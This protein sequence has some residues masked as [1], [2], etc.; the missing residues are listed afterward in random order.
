[1]NIPVFAIKNMKRKLI[2]TLLLVLAVMAVTGTLFSATVFISSMQNALRIGTHRLGADIILAPKEY[3]HQARS[4]LLAGEPTTFYISRDIIDKARQVEGVEAASPQLF[5][6]PSSF[7]C[8]FNVDVF[9]VAFDP[10]T[11]FTI[12]PWIKSQKLGSLGH[13]KVIVGRNVPVIA[14]DQISFFGTLFEVAANLEPTGMRFFD[15]SVFLTMDD[16]YRMAENSPEKAMQ[17][18]ELPRDE[19]STVLIKVKEGYDPARVAIKLEYALSDI[20]AIASDEVIST[21]RGQ[22]GGL[23]KG[24]VAVSVVFW[25]FALVM[26]GFAFYMIVNERRK[27]IG[28]LRA[29]G[30]K[31]RHIFKL[32]ISEALFISS[33]GGVLGLICGAG[34]L[35]ALRDTLMV[36]L[37]L[38][39]LLPSSSF[40]VELTI[41]AVGFALVTGL[42]S[43]LLPALH[44]SRMDPYDIIRQS[45]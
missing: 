3:E 2:R 16:A 25:A 42:L 43:S 4:A 38:P 19:I 11:D 8:C 30:S 33:I 28:M 12:Q 15:Q 7:V 32:I 26:I 39:Y 1:M 6:K 10:E 20:K 36:T 9:L 18:I 29:I 40:L 44:A 24:I 14:G 13:D 23:M 22:L 17:A 37:K 27:E 21:V 31:R 5:I 35:Y 34:L 45:E 41:G